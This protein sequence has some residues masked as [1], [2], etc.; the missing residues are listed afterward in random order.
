MVLRYDEVL[1]GTKVPGQRVAIMGAGGIGFDVAVF[2]SQPSGST[3]IGEFLDSWG[4]DRSGKSPG[5]LIKPAPERPARKIT[6]LQRKATSAGRTLG[7]TTG[8]AIKAEL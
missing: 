5:G 6:M 4:V 3:S 8:W 1:S 7:L 2:L